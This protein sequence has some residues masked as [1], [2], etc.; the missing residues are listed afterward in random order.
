MDRR[1]GMNPGYS[2]EAGTE[3]RALRSRGDRRRHHPALRLFFIPLEVLVHRL[4][5]GNLVFY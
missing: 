5:T 4:R 1:R 2:R 3:R